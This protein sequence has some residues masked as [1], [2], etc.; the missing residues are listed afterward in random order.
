MTLYDLQ[1]I[2]VAADD[3]LVRIY[4]LNDGDC[5]TIYNGLLSDIPYS[6]EDVEISSIDNVYRGD[7]F[8]GINIELDEDYEEDE[9]DEE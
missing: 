1:C 2:M 3:Q 6:L 5:E 7:N 4:N 9:E 8:I